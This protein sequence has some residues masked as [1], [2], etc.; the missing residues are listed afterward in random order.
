M[1]PP[2]RCEQAQN[3]AKLRFISLIFCPPTLKKCNFNVFLYNSAQ[4]RGALCHN[5]PQ[6]R[7][8]KPMRCGGVKLRVRSTGLTSATVRALI[9]SALGAD[10]QRLAW[11]I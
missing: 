7:Y 11:W 10:M 3:H 1:H 2:T 8:R 5:P 6:H 9:F 4:K